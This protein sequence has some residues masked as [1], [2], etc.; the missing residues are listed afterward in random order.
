MQKYKIL[1][2]NSVSAIA[3]MYFDKFD[4]V[5]KNYLDQ[6]KILIEKNFIHPSSWSKIFESLNVCSFDIVPNFENLQRKWLQT[7]Y[8]EIKYNYV[9]TV[10][11]QIE[12]YKPDIIFIYA[13]AFINSF[14]KFMRGDLKTRF[15]FI[16]IV[17]GLWGDHLIGSN[18]KESFSDLDFVFTNCK[19]TKNKF[20][21]DGMKAF[22]LGNAFDPFI[23]KNHQEYINKQTDKKFDIM[24]SGDTGYGKFDHVER[25]FLLKNL[26]E[27]INLF[28]FAN[29]VENKSTFFLDIKNLIRINLIRSLGKLPT[30]TILKINSITDNYKFKRILNEA[31]L[32]KTDDTFLIDYFKNEKP[33]K[34]IYPSRV[35]SLAY[36]IREYYDNIKSSRI[37]LNIHREDPTDIGNIRVFE[38]TGLKSFLLTDRSSELSDYFKENEHYVGY[39]NQKDCIDKIEYFLKNKKEREEISKNASEYCLRNHTV[40]NRC[41]FIDEIL[42]KEL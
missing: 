19:L 10:F 24:F 38:V 7:Y 6:M 32:C 2:I 23:I 16:K 20:E 27:K 5:N 29:E 25:F 26:M 33:L 9:N 28:I 36:S 40:K 39:K 30:N 37:L 41:E 13:G 12:H 21:N 4:L 11:K 17:T 14:P 34:K 15:P 35:K 3:N 31:I 1:R 18:Y 8:P 42:R 22:H